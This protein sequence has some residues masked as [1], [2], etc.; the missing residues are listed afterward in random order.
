[1]GNPDYWAVFAGTLLTASVTDTNWFISFLK[2]NSASSILY[3]NG[4]SDAAGN[5]GSYDL[6]GLSIGCE[7][8]NSD[9]FI[10]KLA[11]LFIIDA[12]ASDAVLNQYGAYLQT[13]FP[14][15]SYTDIT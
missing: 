14:S 1:V 13:I 15:L 4:V 5:I 6:G 8:D 2:A 9:L 12:L 3:K 10:G 11:A 7:W